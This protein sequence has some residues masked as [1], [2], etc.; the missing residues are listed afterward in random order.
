MYLTPRSCALK[1]GYNVNFMICIITIRIYKFSKITIT[2]CQ[3]QREILMRSRIFHFLKM[4]P[5]RLLVVM[6]KSGTNL[7]IKINFTNER[8]LD[9]MCLQV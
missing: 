8:Q 5:H 9:I 3:H 6:T 2:R 1:N 7:M 4:A